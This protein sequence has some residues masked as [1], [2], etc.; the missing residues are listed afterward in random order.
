MNGLHD[1]GGMHGFGPIVP[2]AETPVFHEAWHR[3]AMAIT[4]AMGAAGQWSIDE[5]RHAR[6]CLPPA[7]M[8][9]LSYYERWIA[10]L[11]ALLVK[12]GLVTEA[13]LREGKP[14]ANAPKATPALRVDRVAEVLAKGSPVARP[15][16]REPRFK[17][18]DRVR[19]RNL[20]PPTHIRLPRYARG[21]QGE[22]VLFHGGHIFADL[23]AHRRDAPAEPLYAV[24]FTAAELWGLQGDPRQ[25]VTLDL[26]EPHLE[27]A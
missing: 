5:S 3:R 11:A 9:S 21:K 4:L 25:S 2:E 20:N 14:A 17:S 10:A 15:L 22:I 8:M 7:D 19:A 24:R 27:P 12:H 6:E 26:W 1:V 16:D 13:E 18:G 23:N